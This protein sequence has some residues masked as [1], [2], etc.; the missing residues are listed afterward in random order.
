MRRGRRGYQE[1]HPFSTGSRIFNPFFMVAGVGVVLYIV[2]PA[3]DAV[4]LARPNEQLGK[5]EGRDA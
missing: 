1:V 4:M 3:G 5:L 2:T